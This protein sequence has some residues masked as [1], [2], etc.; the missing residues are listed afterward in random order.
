M[1]NNFDDDLISVIIPCY[2]GGVLLKR[3]LNS[4][5]NQTWENIE[6]IL[7]D[8]GSKDEITHQVINEFQENIFVN[9]ISQQN[10]G[11]PAARN[12]GIKNAKGKYLFFLDSDDWIEPK[13]LEKM[14][15]CLNNNPKYF[16]VFS[17][18]ILE[19]KANN[20]IKKQY[21]FFEQLFIN[22][23]PYSI[24]ISREILIKYGCYDEKMRSGYEDWEL[25]IRLGSDDKFGMR[26]SKPL[27]H[28][29]V[30]DSG[31]LISKT[32]KNHSKIW[33]YIM[34][35]HKNLYSF[36]IIFKLWKKWRKKDSSYP[37]I[38]F[39]GWYLLFKI[40]PESLFSKLFV[41]LRNYK[42]FFTR[43]KN[44]F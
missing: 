36:K 25:N 35:K 40:L 6:I 14:Y 7:V 9:I 30:S 29:N 15:Y 23:I 13:T 16:F 27:F 22:Q 8:D 26:L 11:L 34:N 37:L 38:I 24:F 20:I 39:F 4:A 5:I 17:D 33:K 1:N 2:D 3:A 18:I 10:K 31:M 43:Q 19:G 41:F 12:I 42:W 32:S 21:N 28:Y 44:F